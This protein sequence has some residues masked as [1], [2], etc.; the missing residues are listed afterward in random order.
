ML[1]VRRFRWRIFALTLSAVVLLVAFYLDASVQNWIAQHQD[2]NIR[3]FMQRI[4]KLGD[5]PGHMLLGCTGLL[6][7]NLRGHKKWMRIFVAML[8]ACALAGSTTR[9]IK[10]IAGRSRPDVQ[11]EVGWNGLQLR[12][13]YNSFPSGHTAASTAFFATLALASWRIGLPL[14]VIPFLIGFSR[15]YVVAHHLSDVIAATLIGLAIA[16]FV[17]RLI[18]PESANYSSNLP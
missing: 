14:L 9:V 5:W 16:Y 13:R 17:L 3:G 15:L 7:A 8:L 1:R 4:S 6:I 12:S 18:P 10:I 11:N 2:A